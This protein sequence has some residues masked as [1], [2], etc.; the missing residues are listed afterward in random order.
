MVRLVLATV[1]VAAVPYTCGD[2]FDAPGQGNY[3]ATLTVI[4]RTER[5]VTLFSQAL[6]IEVPP[7][8]E[9]D[10]ENA[11]I[12]SWQVSSPGR[13]MI[14]S[15][16]GHAETH[17]YLIVTGVVRQ[18]STRPDPLPACTGLLQPGS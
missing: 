2:S 18:V 6:T 10:A 15:T 1:L 8:G 12:N 9:V 5:V 3:R 7:C 4:N 17:S 11:L 14:R 16:G 13:D